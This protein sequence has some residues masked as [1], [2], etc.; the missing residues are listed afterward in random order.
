MWKKIHNDCP[1]RRLVR[2]C[3]LRVGSEPEGA[4]EIFPSMDG[5]VLD[6]LGAMSELLRA[7]TDRL[8]SLTLLA[9]GSAL[10]LDTA[11]QALRRCRNLKTLL[12][13]GE[14]VRDQEREGG[15][16]TLVDWLEKRKN[17]ALEHFEVVS[18]GRK[19]PLGARTVEALARFCP[20]LQKAGRLETW[21][22]WKLKK[23]EGVLEEQGFSETK[24]CNE[25]WSAAWPLTYVDHVLCQL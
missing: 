21:S 22:A 15:E 12:A 7:P 25:L 20:R 4:F 17:V 3:W 16:G 9:D 19:A 5:A 23:A 2:R 14:P 18:V 11:I 1:I 6:G 10:P 24:E 8:V 13:I